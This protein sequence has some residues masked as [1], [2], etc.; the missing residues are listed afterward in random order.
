MEP[1]HG[2][3]SP[4]HHP[5]THCLLHIPKTN[6]RRLRI[7]RQQRL[8]VK[9]NLKT[10]QQQAFQTLQNAGIVL[11]KDELTAIEIADFGLNEFYTTGL[12][13]YTYEN[14]DRY[15][16]KELILFPNQTCPE[17][18]H[19]AVYKNQKLIDIR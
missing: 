16:A 3:V 4:R 19:P 15:C 1:N 6:H 13:L 9:E 17:H 10:L 18:K 5:S 14:N 11:R 12:A 8:S 7:N 2:R